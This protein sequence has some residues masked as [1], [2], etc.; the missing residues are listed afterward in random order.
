VVSFCDGEDWIL[1]GGGGRMMMK[2][3]KEVDDLFYESG[4]GLAKT[5]REYKYIVLSC[6]YQTKT[7]KQG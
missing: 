2:G 4:N 1:G 3:I 6:N 5:G 7:K